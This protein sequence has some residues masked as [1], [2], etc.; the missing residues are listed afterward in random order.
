MCARDS[1]SGGALYS[2]PSDLDAIITTGSPGDGGDDDVE[3]DT[4]AA[5]VARAKAALHEL[6]SLIDGSGLGA[7][8]AGG[9]GSP[10]LEVEVDTSTIVG[11]SAD[12]ASVDSNGAT[13]GNGGMQQQLGTLAT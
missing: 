10:A 13:G 2:M 3:E 4:V 8:E 1:D 5:V 7:S 12:A 6:A 11:G 9:G